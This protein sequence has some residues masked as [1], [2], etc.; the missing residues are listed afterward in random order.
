[1]A[2]ISA[3]LIVRDEEEFLPYC[4][5]SIKDFCEEI[6][7]LDTGSNDRTIEI[8]ESFGAIV[9]KTKW[10]NDFAFARN[11]SHST[12]S[13]DWIFWP[14]ADEAFL[15]K[16][17]RL[18]KE[19]ILEDDRID[20]VSMPR[21]NFWKNDSQYIWYPD[22]Q[23]KFYRNCGY[24]WNNKI[25]EV[26]CDIKNPDHAR[27]LRHSSAH[28]F[29]YAYI[30][31]PEDVQRKMARYIKIEN[32]QMSEDEVLS[33]ST[34]H[35]FF[36]DG[37]PDGIRKYEGQKP[38]VFE[39]IEIDDKC[40]K[41]KGN[42]LVD[43]TRIIKNFITTSN[44]S[45]FIPK[46][47]LFNYDMVP[48]LTSIIIATYNKIEYLKPCIESIFQS[49]NELYELIIV[50]NGS[51]ENSVLDYLTP[52]ENDG[53]LRVVKSKENLGF[54]KGYNLGVSESRGQ[55]VCCLNNDTLVTSNWIHKFKQA[56]KSKEKIGVIG[57]VS[58]DNPSEHGQINLPLG[59]SFG[60]YIRESDKE[61]YKLLES[62]WV[63]GL[64]IFF[65]RKLCEE[66]SKIISPKQSGVL[67]H[68][69]YKIGMGEDTDLNFQI[70]HRLGRKNYILRNNFV[71]HH[72]HKTLSS[73]SDDWRK[74]Q[75]RNDSLLR[76]RWP[77]IFPEG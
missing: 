46:K 72:G 39:Y 22:T 4:L 49:T 68:D 19:D 33:C 73:I 35:S 10:R 31:K 7:V 59:S 65:E 38:E 34:Q 14:D 24:K 37:N 28:I 76:K 21:Y 54:A 74:I 52:L 9:I 43:K 12:A 44:M 53:K 30:K 27:K 64:C 50:D 13:G 36:K 18:L 47:R 15:E 57:P 61:G 66:L 32:P 58:N 55:F 26:I 20:F 62:S 29:H 17:L 41:Y 25:H 67:F 48:D 16:D 69:E 71:Y 6:I 63:T 1:M 5:G 11:L 70:Q 23:F 60:D 8:A 75:E 2:T 56:Y 42:L 40:I 51:T 77:E 3:C 45:K